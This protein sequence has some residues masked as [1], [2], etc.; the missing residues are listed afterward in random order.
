[1]DPNENQEKKLH[2]VRKDKTEKVC[3]VVR[4]SG[5]D[6][7]GFLV[8]RR[9]F[10]NASHKTFHKTIMDVTHPDGKHH[11]I[12]FI[13]YEFV[14]APE[15]EVKVK[16]YGNAKSCS[17]SYLR[18]YKSTSKSLQVAKEKGK[19]LKR[20]V[21]DGEI[22]VGGLKNCNSEGALPRKERQAKYLK[23]K[24]GKGRITDPILGAV[25]KSSETLLFVSV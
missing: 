9:P 11:N 18:A 6:I 16:Q 7:N 14:G 4:I 17:I 24:D 13:R 5:D 23:N 8:C 25:L 21:H 22:K 12:V 15:H 19:T 2:S 10:V 20:A 1:M 3:K